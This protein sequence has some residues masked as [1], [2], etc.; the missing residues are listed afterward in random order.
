[1]MQNKKIYAVTGGIGSGKTAVCRILAEFGYPVFSCD[2]VYAELT[3]GG[4]LVD[5]LDEVFKGV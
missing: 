3:R 1:M 2:V 5:R 4:Q